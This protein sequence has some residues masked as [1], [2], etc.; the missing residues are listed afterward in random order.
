MQ[1]DSREQVVIL[2]SRRRT[3]SWAI[4]KRNQGPKLPMFCFKCYFIKNTG[5]QFKVATE[6]ALRWRS[7]LTRSSSEMLLNKWSAFN[8][9][10]DS[11][12]ILSQKKLRLAKTRMLNSKYSKCN[13]YLRAIITFN[14]PPFLSLARLLNGRRQIWIL[15]HRLL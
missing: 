13:D 14:A 8:A 6:F 3:S 12:A 15:V 10:L 2:R 11:H 5:H 4:V 7:K 9:S 1:N